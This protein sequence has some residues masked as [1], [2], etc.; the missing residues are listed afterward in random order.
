LIVFPRSTDGSD[1]PSLHQAV[2][3][4]TLGYLRSRS[5]EALSALLLGSKK[6]REIAKAYVGPITAFAS[7]GDSSLA[8]LSPLGVL[9]LFREYF[10]E[11][12]TFLG[13]PVG[14]AWVSPGAS[15]ELYEISTRK[16]LTDREIQTALQTMTRSETATLEQDEIS[17]AVKQ[18]N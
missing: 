8:V 11:F 5:P 3:A 7:A 16:V 10:Y 14:H 1:G 6:G 2:V 12:K 18:D 13:S 9:H 15:V 4:G 17:D